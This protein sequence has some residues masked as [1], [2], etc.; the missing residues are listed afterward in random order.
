[1]ATNH[2]QVIYHELI[3]RAEREGWTVFQAINKAFRA[4]IEAA[5]Q[6]QPRNKPKGG[7]S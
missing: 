1:M 3:S 7:A 6:P 4:G 2:T 5:N